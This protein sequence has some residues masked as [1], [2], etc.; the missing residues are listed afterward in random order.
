M[1]VLVPN[2]NPTSYFVERAR[3]LIPTMT[4]EDELDFESVSDIDPVVELGRNPKIKS[5]PKNN[6]EFI[7][8]NITEG[9]IER[10]LKYK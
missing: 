6:V 1:G 4:A 10:S 9:I 7:C 3:T 5:K 2:R 8:F